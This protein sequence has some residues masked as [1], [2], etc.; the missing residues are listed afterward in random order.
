MAID[1]RN[2]AAETNAGLRAPGQ[3]VR[4]SDGDASAPRLGNG[5]LGRDLEKSTLAKRVEREERLVPVR[6]LEL[7]PAHG[8]ELS[9]DED[10][11]ELA[12]RLRRG[13]DAGDEVV[14]E[15]RRVRAV[16]AEPGELR[17]GVQLRRGRRP[18]ARVRAVVGPVAEVRA[19]RRRGYVPRPGDDAVFE[20]GALAVA[21]FDAEPG[22]S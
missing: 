9:V 4:N 16:V 14:L 15:R 21:P 3:R 2:L 10:P 13:A 19:A 11:P 22:V 1:I 18:R 7:T 5:I 20:D 12:V 8:R 17:R 6:D